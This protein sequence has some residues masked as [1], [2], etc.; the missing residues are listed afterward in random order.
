MEEEE[1]LAEMVRTRWV[2]APRLSEEDGY[3]G[4]GEMLLLREG[5]A[6]AL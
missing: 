4:A 1:E 2:G 6:R 5:P 3:T